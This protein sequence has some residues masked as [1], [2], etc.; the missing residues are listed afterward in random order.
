MR[1]AAESPAA[2][3]LPTALEQG[4][5]TAL[6]HDASFADVELGGLALAGQH[7]RG[8]RFDTARLSGVDL[9][10]SSLEHLCI[11]DAEVQDCNLANL[12]A[13]AARITNVV[14]SASRMTGIDLGESVLMDVT[15]RG[16]RIRPGVLQHGP[17][18]ARDVRGLRAVPERLPRRRPGGRPLPRV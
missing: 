2:P 15:L 12:Q 18:G 5:I 6:D 7:A 4:A 9:S 14:I 3:R 8:V 11:A 1:A 16:C 13:R 10:S 17:S